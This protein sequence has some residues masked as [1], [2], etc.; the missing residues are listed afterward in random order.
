MNGSYLSTGLVYE[1]GGVQ[2]L[3]PHVRTQNRGELPRD[4]ILL[5]RVIPEDG[6][7]E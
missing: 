6:V 5:I 7:G 3:L 2:G 1:C 4:K